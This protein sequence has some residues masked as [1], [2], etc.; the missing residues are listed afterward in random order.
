MQSLVLL[1]L[2][3]ISLA[4]ALLAIVLGIVGLLL[5]AAVGAI[6]LLVRPDLRRRVSMLIRIGRAVRGRARRRRPF[7]SDPDRPIVDYQD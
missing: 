5:A 4:G 6:V 1:A 2:V 3:A 7:E